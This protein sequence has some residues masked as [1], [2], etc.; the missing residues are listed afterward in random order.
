[1]QSPQTR[2]RGSSRASSAFPAGSI[3]ITA[4]TISCPF[5]VFSS[6]KLNLSQNPLLKF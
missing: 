5:L 2:G 3:E 1:M 6:G 4:L